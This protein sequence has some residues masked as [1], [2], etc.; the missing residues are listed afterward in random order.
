M[1]VNRTAE[2]GEYALSQNLMSVLS[3]PNSPAY[4]LRDMEYL[5]LRSVNELEVVFRTQ[6]RQSKAYEEMVIELHS[7]MIE[8]KFLHKAGIIKTS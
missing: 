5:Y 4:W 7:N 3:A 2:T 1:G 6:F 8:Y